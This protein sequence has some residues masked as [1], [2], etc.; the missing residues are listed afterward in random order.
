[1]SML[2]KAIGVGKVWQLANWLQ[3]RRFFEKSLPVGCPS[4]TLRAR[5][6]VEQSRNQRG[7]CF[8]DIS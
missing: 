1:M 7:N 2:Q 6:L 8:L 3:L 5:L 4:T